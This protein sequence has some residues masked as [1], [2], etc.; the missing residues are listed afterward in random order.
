MVYQVELMNSNYA[1]QCRNT[2]FIDHI[3][4]M[5]PRQSTY[6]MHYSSHA[7]YDAKTIYSIKLSGNNWEIGLLR[8]VSVMPLKCN[9]MEKSKPK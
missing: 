7:Q 8:N 5:K 9:T 6:H 4:I 3:H 2:L 1:F